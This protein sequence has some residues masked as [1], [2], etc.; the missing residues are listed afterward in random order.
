MEGVLLITHSLIFI[1][2]GL[3]KLLTSLFPAFFLRRKIMKSHILI[4][5]ASATI[6]ATATT[7]TTAGLAAAC[8]TTLIFKQMS[9]RHDEQDHQADQNYHR[10]QIH[11]VPLPT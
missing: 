3:F 4:A 1:G 5:T 11:A 7:V 10:S 2:S 8:A 9:D 6:T